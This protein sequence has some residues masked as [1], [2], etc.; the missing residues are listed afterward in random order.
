[1]T[2]MRVDDE[3]K[4]LAMRIS[5]EKGVSCTQATRYIAQENKIKI[6]LQDILKT[7]GRKKRLLTWLSR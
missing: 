4:K 7:N 1:M 3:F 6:D 2:L 5:K